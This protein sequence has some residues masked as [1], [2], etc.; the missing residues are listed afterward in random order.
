MSR[1]NKPANSPMV[2]PETKTAVRNMP[3]TTALPQDVGAVTAISTSVPDVKEEECDNYVKALYDF[4]KITPED[5]AAIYDAVGYKGF[6]RRDIMK[7]LSRVV[8]DPKIATEIIIA[9]ALQG[10]QRA[11]RVKLTNGLT[12]AAMGLPASGGQGTKALTL[13]RIL[14][15]TAD[16]AAFFLKKLNVPKRLNVNLPGWLQFPSAG[17]IKLPEQYKIAHLEFSRMFSQV[18]GGNFNEQIYITMQS[19]AYLDEKLELFNT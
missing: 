18:I 15:A 6:N 3:T 17:S 2:V 11:C 5:L 19:N 16:L 12:P 1:L 13:N 14:S 10:P 9:V 4:S 7:Q 8:K